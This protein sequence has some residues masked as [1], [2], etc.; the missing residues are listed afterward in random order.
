[1]MNNRLDSHDW[2]IA[3]A[4]KFQSGQEEVEDT[5]ED[6]LPDA[7]RRKANGGGGGDGGFS[8]TAVGAIATMAPGDRTRRS[9]LS[10]SLMVSQTRFPG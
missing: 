7:E 8:L 2:R 5:T 9:S 10:P 1:M 3:R 6:T 4:E